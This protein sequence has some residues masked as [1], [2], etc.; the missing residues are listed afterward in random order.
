MARHQPWQ[1]QRA[2]PA[3]DRGG[4]LRRH[5]D[6]RTARR[7]VEAHVP[8]ELAEELVIH[9][10][11]PILVIPFARRVPA[12]RRRPLIAWD[13]SRESRTA[14]H[15]SL[16]LIEGCHDAI[17]VSLDKPFEEAERYCTEVARHLACHGIKARTEV[18][19]AEDEHMMDF[20]LNRVTDSTPTCS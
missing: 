5:G 16:R 11:R 12:R 20:L 13:Q 7:A 18:L 6:R 10:G 2:A 8:P 9:S 17:V 14:L 3:P 1:R 15:A 4:P 19:M